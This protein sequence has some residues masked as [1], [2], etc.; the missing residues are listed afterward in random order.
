[1]TWPFENDTRAIVKKLANKSIRENH[2]TSISI[3]VAILIAS[4]FLCSLFTFVYSYWNQEIQQEK[5]VSGD[6][7]AQLLE[8]RAGQLDIIENNPNIQNF[9]VKGDNQ[10]ALLPDGM[11][12]SYLLIQNCDTEYWNTMREKNLIL[13]GRVPQ[14]AGEIVVGKN[15][16]EQNSSVQIGDTLNLTLGERKIDNMTVDFLSPMLTGESFAR[17]EEL[18]YTIVGEIDMTISTA[19]NGYPAYGWLDKTLIDR[20]TGIVVYLQMK[21][22]AKV[23]DIIPQIAEEIGLQMDEYQNYPYRYNTA[24]L[25]LNGIFAPGH[26]WNSDLPKLV[27]ILI[28][29]STASILIFIY[30]ISGAFSISAKHK[31]KE[32]GILKAI[33]ATPRQIRLLIIYESRKLSILPI[34]ISLGLGHLFSYG[35]MSYYSTL[36]SGVTGNSTAVAFSPWVVVLSMV[37]SFLTVRLAA[38][39]PA[40]QMAKLNPIDAIRENWGSYTLKKSNRH[41]VLT[42]YFGFLGKISANSITANKKLFHTCTVTL[43]LCMLLMFSFLAVFAASDIDNTKAE[44]DY[45]FNVNVTI[46]TGQQTDNALI[47]DLKGLPNV[48]GQATYTTANCAV[49]LSSSDLSADFLALGGFETKIAEEFVIQR[50]GLYRVP[51]CLIG[52]EQDAYNSLVGAGA[53]STDPESAIIVNTVTKNPD[54]R[55][56]ESMIEQIPYLNLGNG[57]SLEVSE[58][59]SDSIQGDYTFHVNISAIL[60]TMP[61]IGSTLDLYTLPIIVPMDEYYNIIQ[62]FQEDRAIYNYRTYM[63]FLADDG[64][65]AQV[66]YEA[67]QICDTYLSAS[68]F[69]TSS[70]AE[71]ALERVQLTNATMLIVYSLAALF[72][73]VG[74]SSAISAIL[75]SLY[76]RRKE[77]AMLRS[78]GL[79]KRG[80]RR[81]LY[82]EGF[83]L[84]AR[85]IIIG[86]PILL[87]ICLAQMWIWNVTCVEFLTAFSLWG[88]VVYIVIV[89]AAISGIYTLASMKIR[90]DTIVEVLKDETV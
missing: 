5:Y 83:L 81:L 14:T 17:T 49:W 27:F 77:F 59:F 58:K 38:S 10:T 89:L 70:K 85:P 75:N 13:Q 55:G 61:N 24:L 2:R 39:R 22:P 47:Q 26:F 15:F 69:Y 48:K 64:L 76:Q 56:Y 52:L 12:L 34:V 71:R 53:D 16:F 60:Q 80:L 35:I 6:W 88:V 74:L 11:E 18:E 32:L 50:D 44:Q 87:V 73:V 3:M 20:D 86:L 37:L 36:A 51:C 68:D 57:Q 62:N 1:M 63:N 31:V 82:I 66:Q 30:I 23:F 54:G 84:A 67:N 45:Y 40:R 65:D 43:C 41:A 9:M 19:Y 4:T 25:G 79:D 90:K 78:V 7:D 72:G 46:Q 29:I 28:I 33:G 8:V 21:Q 42:K